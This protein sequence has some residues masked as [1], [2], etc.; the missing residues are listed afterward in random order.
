MKTIPVY[1]QFYQN[2]IFKSFDIAR[3]RKN[4]KRLKF[5]RK[6][7]YWSRE[8]IQKWQLEKINDLLHTAKNFSPYYAETLKLL[9]LPLTSVDSFQDIP[10]LTKKDLKDNF[11]DIICNNAIIKNCE[12]ARTGGSTGEPS[13]FYLSLNSKDWNRGS[14]YRS[15]EWAKVFLGDRTI[16]M[17]GSHYDQ[18][19]FQKLSNKVV[20]FLQR[21]KDL[22]V[23][24]VTDEIYDDYYKI[25]SKYKPTSIWGYSSGIY[26]FSKF[27]E[28][29]YPNANFN[30][31]NGII[32]SSETLQPKWREKINDVFGDS[33]VFDHYG[34]R[35]A[36]IASECE[37]HDG[38]HIHSEVI[39]PEIVGKDG[40]HK[41]DCELG[42]ILITDLSNQ[43]FPLI[44]YEIG[45]VGMM[46]DKK[47][48]DC[49]VNLPLL[50]NIEGRIS[51]VIVLKNKL[52]T[53]YF[54]A[55]M[56]SVGGIDSY[57]IVQ[58]NIEKLTIKIVKNNEYQIANQ[59]KIDNAL[60]DM[61]GQS[62]ELK[63]EYVEDIP[64]SESGKRRFVV[65][66]IASDYI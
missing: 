60:R 56:S 63:Y 38:Y 39:F 49:G 43:A 14:V 18:Q 42:K 41:P 24:S 40:C 55:L 59:I 46:S 9:K 6:S 62:I 65:S 7:Q 23:A 13:K 20:F 30:Y 27:I 45:D 48:C 4:I 1:N 37:N 22:P 12:L 64:V 51:D 44:R 17:T 54:G 33:S 29:H 16:Q 25:I 58:E 53:P 26:F 10:V 61:A 11:K 66:K 34:S 3:S 5:L 50:E 8:R 32:T 36:Y 47:K 21:Y 15:A 52:L 19:E 57:Q 35:E 31:I 2:I 28:K